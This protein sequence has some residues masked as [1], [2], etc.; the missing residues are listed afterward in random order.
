MTSYARREAFRQVAAFLAGSPL[1]R[2]QRELPYTAERIPALDEIVNVFEF[3]PL[4]R[5][6]IPKQNYDFIAGGVDNEWSLRHNREAFDKIT[7]RP[8]MLVNTSK[9]DLSTTVLGTRI[10]FPVLIAPTAAH[11]LAHPDAEIATAKAAAASNTI[12]CLS[13][14]SSLPFEKVAAATNS[15]KWWQLYPREDDDATR[16]RAE[17][18]VEA[19]YKVVVLTVDGAYSSHRERLLRNRIR[20]QVPVGDNPAGSRRS[21]SEE[22]P[23]PYRLDPAGVYKWDWTYVS[24]L[25]DWAKTPVL[26][27]WI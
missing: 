16:D 21:R 10:G 8:R 11:Q 22:P 19:G 3:E 24:K 26:V 23:H 4:C 6:R 20:A 25:K 15:M 14:N 1:A 2:A 17:R 5:Y 9:M 13:S 7:L 27:K 18:A 12:L